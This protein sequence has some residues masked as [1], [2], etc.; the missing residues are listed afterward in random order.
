VS[1]LFPNEAG[2]L[3]ME[4]KLFHVEAGFYSMHVWAHS[5]DE[6]IYMWTQR[7]CSL[8]S[9]QQGARTANGLGFDYEGPAATE[10]AL[11]VLKNVWDLSELPPPSRPA[12]VGDFI[13]PCNT[14][15]S[16]IRTAMTAMGIGKH[17]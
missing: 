1:L 10:F 17:S 4:I 6:A 3:S 14:R 15:I 16:A 12:Y 5:A 11:T 9:D 8:W 13:R 7:H 2:V